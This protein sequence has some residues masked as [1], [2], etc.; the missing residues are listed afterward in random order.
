MAGGTLQRYAF[1]VLFTVTLAIG[2]VIYARHLTI[3]P[4]GFFI[5]ESSVAYN[6][7]TISES[8]CDEYGARWPLYFRA[9]GDYKNP[10]YVYLL[11]IIFRFTG[12]SMVVARML[13]A[14]SGV[15]AAL[16]I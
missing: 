1:V 11:A 3:N 12:P 8:G 7:L 10:V 13:S 16:A 4:P 15:F 9:F 6:A 2:V 5:D 14:A